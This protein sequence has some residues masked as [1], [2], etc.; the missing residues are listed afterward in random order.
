MEEEVAQFQEVG[1]FGKL[2]DGIA[3]VEKGARVAVDERDVGVAGRRRNES[4]IVGEI[5]LA[6]QAADVN[7]VLTKTGFENGEFDGSVE[8][9]DIQAGVPGLPGLPLVAADRAARRALRWFCHSTNSPSR[10]NEPIKPCLFRQCA[11]SATIRA[12]FAM[13][14]AYL[15][16]HES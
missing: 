7:D 4:R 9:V 10:L 1:L 15:P 5:A 11:R 13:I 6:G 12:A 2:L 8:A 14:R 3:A 16:I